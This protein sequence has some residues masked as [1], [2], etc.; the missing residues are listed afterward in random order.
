MPLNK[1][2][3]SI[4]H[5]YICKGYAE[6]RICLIMAPYASIMPEYVV[7][8]FNMA[9]HNWILTNVPEYGWKCLN[10]LFW[11]CQGSEYVAM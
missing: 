11:L 3:F 5:G 9:T 1:S 2:G 7:M 8:S 4:W 10:K 6:F